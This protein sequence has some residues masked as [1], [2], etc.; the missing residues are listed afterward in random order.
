MTTEKVD[1][2]P[3]GDDKFVSVRLGKVGN[4]ST[5]KNLYHKCEFPKT[6][7]EKRRGPEEKD[8]KIDA[9]KRHS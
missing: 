3:G 7:F 6:L 1:F 2:I 9:I 4:M 8:H 5:M